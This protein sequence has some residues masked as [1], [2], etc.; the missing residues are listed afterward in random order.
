MSSNKIY[1]NRTHGG[2]RGDVFTRPCVVSY[3][4][5][6]VGYRADRN[7][8]HLSI[9]EP[10]CGEGAFVAEIT[11][12]LYKSSV[13]FGF[14]FESAFKEN[15]FAGDID[16][17]K[18][19]T[20]IERL[21]SKFNLTNDAFRH[22]FVE[23][24]LLS[25]HLSVDIIIGNPPYIRYE[26]IPEKVLSIYKSRFQSFYYRADMYVLFYEKT[27]RMLK[28]GGKHGFICSNRWMK[29]TYGKKLRNLV[30]KSFRM[31]KIIDLESVQA[32]QE[33]VCAYPSITFITNEQP[34]HNILFCKINTLEELGHKAY[35]SLRL[36]YTDDWTNMFIKQDFSQLRTI[37]EQ[38]YHI[39]IGVATGKD[40]VF[41]S[42]YL[43]GSVE[44]E[45]LL[46]CINAQNLKGDR[47][48]WDGRYLLNPFDHNGQLIELTQYP[49]ARHYLCQHFDELSKR[50]KAKKY[51]DR[52]YSTI[53]KIDKEL[54]GKPKVL[55]PDLS[56]NRYLFVDKGEYYPQHNIYYITNGTLR[57]MKILAALLMS[58][59]I[60]EQLESITNHMNGGYARWQSQY[61]KKLR[62][63]IV[64]DISENRQNELLRYYES[65]DIK[66]INSV[67]TQI[68][69]LQQNSNPTRN[70]KR[71]TIKLTFNFEY[72]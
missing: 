4:L 62:I 63:P 67:V 70:N 26:E 19:N 34:S 8:S 53:D 72:A 21:S 55:L 12:R 10:S 59:P 60:R 49:K 32:F 27:L 57:E 35:T 48:N 33:E 14:D 2:Q 41:V 56:G 31:E 25:H 65:G 42:K 52:W 58:S 38:G 61:L 43:K 22:F 40:S 11:N 44:D 6:E 39:G 20:C 64:A 23:D 3:M 69:N 46:P 5:D 47:M 29:N 68:M 7:L 54:L 13:R 16:E 66:G 18:M 71:E 24:F 15:V 45:L 1:G 30:A 17:V 50:H 9:F 51:P 28:R 36:P 37:E